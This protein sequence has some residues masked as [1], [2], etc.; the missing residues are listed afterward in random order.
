M[1]C[2]HERLAT[3]LFA[4]VLLLAAGAPAGAQG[5]ED[6]LAKFTT[7]S[8]S[9]TD[10]GIS[11]VAASGNPLAA[12]VI[13]ALQD[14]RLLF[15][16]DDKRVYVRDK[17]G[18]ILDATTGKAA[19][20]A[21]ANLKPVRLNNRLR[22]STEAALGGLTLMSADPGKRFDAAQAVFKSKDR[23]ALVTLDTAIG[24]ETDQRVKR[25]LQEAR[26]AVILFIVDAKEA[27][28]VA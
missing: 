2:W 16:A 25:A 3:L 18:T 27:D 6:A 4:F 23:N 5:Y 10:A 24:R 13:E 8:Y 26:A 11:A 1:P 12:Q 21:P 17:S 28:K 22:R 20:G 14:G 15:S 9:D 19:G 7:D